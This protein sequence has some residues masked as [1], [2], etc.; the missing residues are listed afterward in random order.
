VILYKSAVTIARPPEVVFPYLVE[1][2]LQATWS[3]VPMRPLTDGPFGPGSQLEVTFGMGPLEA[4]V[5]LLITTV[6]PGRRMTWQTSDG[7]I[8]WEGEYLLVP[9]GDATELRQDGRLTFKGLWRLIEP[10]VGGEIKKGE[11]KELDKLKAV[12]E[13]A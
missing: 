13:A 7:K 2:K 4:K 10:L 5:V 3:D 11:V 6:E 9:S 8:E 1:P 12:V